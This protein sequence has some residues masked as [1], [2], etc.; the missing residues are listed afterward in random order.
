MPLD[1]DK[2]LIHA[3]DPGRWV[4]D[5]QLLPS[6]DPWQIS[7][8]RSTAKQSVWLCHRQSGKST[9]A[10][11]IALHRAIF[12]PGSLVLLVSRSIRQSSELYKKWVTAYDKL[13]SKPGMKKSTE[14]SCELSNGS[15]VV[16]LPDSE[17]T[18][19]GYSSVSLLIEDESSRVSDELH[20]AIRPMLAISEGKLLLLGT[21][22]GKR[23][24]FF[25]IWQADN[26]LSWEKVLVTVA[27][28]KRIS[29]S[30]LD[31][32]KR[33]MPDYF[34]RQE[35]YCE[36]QDNI[37]QIFST[38]L[39]MSCIN[40]DLEPLFDEDRIED[41]EINTDTTPF[42]YSSVIKADIKTFEEG[43]DNV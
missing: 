4:E 9:T 3:L 39:I 14:L 35:Y 6:L 21:P 31:E 23:G 42:D 40:N 38:E 16:S 36:F 22:A 29:K 2:D 43:G 15:R 17:D 26:N 5:L 1:L 41:D 11:L 10:A 13:D 27:D 24:H 18:I 28:C 33:S 7:A 32:E 25:D 20:F 19:R 30:F 12:S 8:L 37:N 34:F